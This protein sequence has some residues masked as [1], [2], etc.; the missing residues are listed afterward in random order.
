MASANVLKYLEGQLLLGVNPDPARWEGV[1]LPFRVADL[2]GL[3]PEV[4]GAKRP[5]RAV[6]MAEAKLSLPDRSCWA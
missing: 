2:D 3:M 1:L 4:F 5:V 6:T